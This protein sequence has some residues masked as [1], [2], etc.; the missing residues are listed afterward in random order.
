MT[1]DVIQWGRSIA[2]MYPKRTA[3]IEDQ[4]Q[5]QVDEEKDDNNEEEKQERKTSN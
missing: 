1:E 2:G 5:D 4:D 3:N